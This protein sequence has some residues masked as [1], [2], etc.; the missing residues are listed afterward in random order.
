MAVGA[1]AAVGESTAAIHPLLVSEVYKDAA[2][3][4][5]EG[6]TGAAGVMKGGIG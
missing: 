4:G 6:V 1:G 5:I 2:F 3:V